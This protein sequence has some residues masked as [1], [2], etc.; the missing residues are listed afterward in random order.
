[1]PQPIISGE[2][3]FTVEWVQDGIPFIH[4]TTTYKGA[5]KRRWKIHERFKARNQ[6]TEIR[7]YDNDGGRWLVN[8]TTP[9]LFG[10]YSF[11][12]GIPHSKHGEL[13]GDYKNA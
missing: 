3:T 2:G 7:I 13:I 5:K 1:M 4:K 11:T 6:A 12:A 10:T 8:A 9:N